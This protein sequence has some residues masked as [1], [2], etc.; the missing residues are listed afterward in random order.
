MSQ[1]RD[2]GQ[3]SSTLMLLLIFVSIL[4]GS[5]TV[6]TVHLLL[7]REQLQRATDAAAIAGAETLFTKPDQADSAARNMLSLH[8]VDGAKVCDA[9]DRSIQ[10]YT[11]VPQEGG[12]GTV[13]VKASILV[14]H[15]SK[16]LLFLHP[17]EVTVRSVAG[18]EGVLSTLHADQAFPIAVSISC[19]PEVKGIKQPP[20]NARKVGDEVS[21]LFGATGAKNAAFT[22]LHQL[23]SKDEIRMRIRKVLGLHHD[24]NYHVD[25]VTVGD[26]INLINGTLGRDLLT[27]NQIETALLEH[28]GIV[29]PLIDD[30]PSYNQQARVV[31]FMGLK[32]LGISWR[33]DPDST[34]GATQEIR[35]RIVPVLARGESPAPGLETQPVGGPYT[36]SPVKITE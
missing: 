23:A 12:F 8:I 11:E 24:P 7:V 4:V 17:T 9:G 18:G 25:A 19:T 35:G 28:T 30:D 36:V 34:S 3:C 33:N 27:N 21:L 20:L 2:S 29:V 5:F 26:T 6:D 1:N 32:V 10:I 13:E 16:F 22:G 15:L 14:H 31:G